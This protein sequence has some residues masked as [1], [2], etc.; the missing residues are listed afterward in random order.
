MIGPTGCGKTEIAR[1]LAKLCGSPFIKVEATKFTEVGYHGRD[2]DQIIKDLVSAGIHQTKENLRNKLKSFSSEIDTIVEEYLLSHLLGPDFP[3]NERKEVKREQLRSGKMDQR[4]IYVEIPDLE[5]IVERNTQA[6]ALSIEDYLD[7]LKRYKPGRTLQAYKEKIQ[8]G[9][10]KKTLA[11]QI[12]EGYMKEQNIIKEALEAV[13]EHGIVF[14]DEIDKIATSADAIKTGT[15]PSAE[16]VQRD[17]LPI[18]EGT[19]ITTKHGDVQTDH[20]LFIASGAFSETRPSDLL[21]ELQGRLPVRVNLKALQKEDLKRI[22]TEPENNLIKQNTELLKTEKIDLKF[23]PEAVDRI[24]EIA[25]EINKTI[26][27]TGARRLTT[28][29]EKILEDIS[30]NALDYEN[31]EVVVTAELV[32]NKVKDM[33]KQTDLRKYLL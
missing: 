22:L 28:V 1:R 4:M 3:E 15:N 11:T 25:D 33:T 31:Q 30:F 17:L 27:N 12:T 24:A 10:A 32:N 13:Q 20:I 8:I 5:K 21:A 26:E 2:V 9:E 23:T 7:T 18:I 14:I 19:M 29:M 16:G 6:D